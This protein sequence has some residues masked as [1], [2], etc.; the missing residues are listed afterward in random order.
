MKKQ[1]VEKY[2]P[3]SVREDDGLSS[4]AKEVVAEVFRLASEKLVALSD[5]PKEDAITGLIELY[6]NGYMRMIGDGDAI[7]IELCSPEDA[8]QLKSAAP[9]PRGKR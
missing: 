4:E 8:P 9:P 7:G 3:R 6:D 1:P 2:L 5:L